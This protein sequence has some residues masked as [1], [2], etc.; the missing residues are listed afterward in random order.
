MTQLEDP[1]VEVLIEEF[2]EVV[3]ALCSN[4]KP[5]SSSIQVVRQLCDVSRDAK[6]NLGPAQFSSL[7]QR[8]RLIESLRNGVDRIKAF[9][10]TEADLPEDVKRY[11]DNLIWRAQRIEDGV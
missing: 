3:E 6:L 2:N 7:A 8:S 11:C 1:I 4:E 9:W 10:G 5:S